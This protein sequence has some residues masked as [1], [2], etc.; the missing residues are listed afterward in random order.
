MLYFDENPDY[1]KIFEILVNEV[2]NGAGSYPVS[3]IADLYR[4]GTGL[5]KILLTPMYYI[6]L[7]QRIAT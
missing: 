7:K 1:T 6:S 3:F 5:E 4:D 2:K